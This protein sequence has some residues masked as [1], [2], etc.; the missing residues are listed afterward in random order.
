MVEKMKELDQIMNIIDKRHNFLLSGGAGSGK[1][2]T[3]VHV[4]KAIIEKY[5]YCNI[6]CITYTNAAAIEIKHRIEKQNLS[7]TTIHDFLWDNI[8]LY[9]KELRKAVIELINTPGQKEFDIPGGG[10]VS[11]D[12]Y[13]HNE[14][15]YR[16]Y[17]NLKDGIISH[18]QVLVVAS[19][20]FEHYPKLAEIVKSKYDY[21]FVDEYQDTD[22]NVIKILLE[23]FKQSRKDCI[24]G[25][26]GDS[27]QSI[28]DN[29]VG[30][31]KEYIY[32][33]NTNKQGIVWE[34]KKEQNRR[35]P[36]RVIDIA[37]QLRT[38]GLKQTA[39][40]DIS[41]PN[42]TTK[43]EI[44]DGV[45]IF[46]YSENYKYELAHEYLKENC[47]WDFN[48]KSQTKEL[49]LTHKLIASKAGFPNLL[50]IHTSDKILQ[51]KNRIVEFIKKNNITSDFSKMSFKDVINN[52]N[53]TFIDEDSRKKLSKTQA[54][55]TFIK[56]NDDLFQ[57]ALDL[58]FE[59]FKSNYV[60]RE[61][62]TDFR[63]NIEGNS[64]T[65]SNLSAAMKHLYKIEYLIR[66]YNSGNYN[67][68]IRKTDFSLLKS[69]ADKVILMDKMNKLNNASKKK[70]GDV[71]DKAHELGLCKIDDNLKRYA[72]K[73]N[74]V[75]YR[76]RNT[77]YSEYINVFD[78]I[79]GLKPYSTQHKTKGLEF[80]N[81]L[82]LLDN[83]NWRKY[84]YATIFDNSL[85]KSEEIKTRTKKMFYVC[86]T[87]AKQQLAVYYPNPSDAVVNGAKQIFGE[88]N[89][90]KLEENR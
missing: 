72:N 50:E 77:D 16:E 57:Y 39:S 28:Y 23:H 40:D 49:D 51:Y 78:Y 37:N 52:L 25:F 20:L 5:P 73:N 84:D 61:H 10:N 81:V 27:M 24:I 59:S 9:Q 47:S 2:Y 64:S 32:D 89:V 8:K 80:D 88:Q 4:I 14:I 85:R 90:I 1:T 33:S 55:E 68:F 15:N 56:T 87:R 13:T 22:K 75:Y 86:C 42:M 83:G 18:D 53:D 43:G 82:L 36:Q 79:L 30:D 34:V 38:D 46:L 44:I 7:V 63:V 54:Q 58:N 31:I 70:I 65:S 17:L 62:L 19:Y 41:A 45:T 3:L 11:N 6:A 71:I 48:D 66:L 21:I 74:Y 76:I 35:N 69:K 60:E 26:F 29:G 67:D 12:D